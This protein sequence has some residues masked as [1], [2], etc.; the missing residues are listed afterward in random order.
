M[1]ILNPN[2]DLHSHTFTYSDGL[3]SVDEMVIMAGRAGLKKFA[4]T[5]HSISHLRQYRIS[6]KTSA[7]CV[8]FRWKNIHNDVDVIFGVEADLLNENGDVDFVNYS[9]TRDLVILSA[10]SGVYKGDPNKITKAYINALK[11]HHKEIDFIGHLCA[12]YFGNEVNVGRVVEV[13]NHFYVPVE[14]NCANL[15]A[16]KTNME[17]LEQMLGMVDEIYVNSDSHTLYDMTYLRIE[18]LKF[19]RSNGYI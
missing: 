7:S 8:R 6:K 5:D 10:H 18:G 17:K 1:K 19:L 13:A 16:G 9:Q 14:L 15:V 3:N 12:N 11:R 2:S 4:I